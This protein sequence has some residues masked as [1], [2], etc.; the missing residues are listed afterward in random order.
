MTRPIRLVL[1]LLLVVIG[2]LM[3][4]FSYDTT[5]GHPINTI[6]LLLGIGLCTGGIAAVVIWGRER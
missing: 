6:F 2:Y 1:S 4:G 5:A 3:L